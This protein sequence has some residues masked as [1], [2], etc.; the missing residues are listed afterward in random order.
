MIREANFVITNSFHGAVFCLIFNTP[1]VVLLSEGEL[2]SM[3]NRIT[4]LLEKVG[5]SDR[6]IG[7][8]QLDDIRRIFSGIDWQLVNNE[9]IKL[10]KLATDFITSNA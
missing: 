9:L 4:D 10:N 7:I 6:S 8:S 5:L 3:N 2:Q 1:F